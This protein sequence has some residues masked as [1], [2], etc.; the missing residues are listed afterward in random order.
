MEVVHGEEFALHE[1]LDRLILL[2]SKKGYPL[3]LPVNFRK[4]E[5]LLYSAYTIMEKDQ[6]TL[7]FSGTFSDNKERDIVMA[8]ELSHMYLA[9]RK[10]PSHEMACIKA[11]ARP[12]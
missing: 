3:S 11:E 10:H 12:R 2:F 7:S 1:S 8:H 9:E 4:D 5:H 6:H